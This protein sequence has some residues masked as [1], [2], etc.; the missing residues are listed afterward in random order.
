M[1][2]EDINCINHKDT[3]FLFYCFD[4][5]SFLCEDCF[6]EH[7]SHNVEIKSDIKKVSDFVELL[8]K[9]NSRNIKKI[10]EDIEIILKDLKEKIE[11][12]FQKF[13][14]YQKN[15]K[16]MKKLKSQMIFLIQNMKNLKIY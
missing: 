14:N 6:R 10:Y 7:K 3:K 1:L 8:K 15:S 12:Y 16:V 5:K 9:S 4:D 2:K 13:K 11:K